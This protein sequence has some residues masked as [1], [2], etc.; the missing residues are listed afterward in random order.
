MSKDNVS[1]ENSSILC[2]LSLDAEITNACSGRSPRYNPYMLI[3][4][5]FAMSSNA[6][7]ERSERL[8]LPCRAA[9]CHAFFF[10]LDV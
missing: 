9:P 7:A 1:F 2:R 4:S 8:A 5:H 6:V 10:S 3:R